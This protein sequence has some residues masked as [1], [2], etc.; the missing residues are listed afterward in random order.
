MGIDVNVRMTDDRKKAILTFA[1]ESGL[2]GT[3]EVD[4]SELEGFLQLF[5]SLHW[6]MA[7][8]QQLP[9]ITG[10][11]LKPA[12]QFKWAVQKDMDKQQSLLAFQHPGYGALGFM[13][14]DEQVKEYIK[15]LQKSLKL[16]APVSTVRK[17][18]KA[19]SASTK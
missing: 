9:E 6:V 14:S 5:S 16:K 3:L 8:G 13:L 4:Q 17:T 18:T 2:T 7:E 15:A 12:Y 10:M 1:P 19:K 11:K